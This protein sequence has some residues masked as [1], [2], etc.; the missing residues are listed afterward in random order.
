MALTRPSTGP[1]SIAL[2]SPYTPPELLCIIPT[3]D[4]LLIDSPESPR[5][6]HIHP[7]VLRRYG[8]AG[9]YM[10]PVSPVSPSPAPNKGALGFATQLEQLRPAT[11]NASTF[12]RSQVSACSSDSKGVGT[13]G[14]Q[15]LFLRW[16][17]ST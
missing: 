17:A 3:Q 4:T 16:S 9:C 5:A 6:M 8:P 1:F 13:R 10:A 12:V 7:R 2:A 15:S 11:D 14:F